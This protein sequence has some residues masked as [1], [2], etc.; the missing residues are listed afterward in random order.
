M[1]VLLLE[2]VRGSGKAGDIVEVTDGYARNFLFRKNL[3]K[4][5]DKAVVSEKASKEASKA[6]TDALNKAKAEKQGAQLK[7][8]EFTVHVKLGLNGKMFGS[9]TSKEIANVIKETG[10]DVDKRQIL[11]KENIKTCGRFQIRIKLYP[12]I[13]VKAYVIVK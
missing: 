10:I 11:L 12:G 2:D 8:K 13:T 1:K 6:R 9:V 7:D 5:A 3:A 4:V